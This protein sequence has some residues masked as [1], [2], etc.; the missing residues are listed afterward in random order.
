MH[1]FPLVTQDNRTGR[2][3][4]EEIFYLCNMKWLHNLLKGFSLTGALFV[5]Q[6]CYGI[7]EPPLYEEGGEAPMSFSLVSKTTGAPLEGIRISASIYSPDRSFSEIGVTGADGK[8][9][10]RIP[11]KRNIE[12]PYI[13]FEDP[14]GQYFVKDTTLTD[15]RE[16]DI[17]VKLDPS[18]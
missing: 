3:I 6:A 13:V 16:R 11:Y 10:V 8:C 2:V 1:F 14:Q 17:T 9:Q 18:L 7:P 5:F 4:N 15:L 12:G